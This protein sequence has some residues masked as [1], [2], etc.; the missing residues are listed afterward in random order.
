MGWIIFFAVIITFVLMLIATSRKRNSYNE[1]A[2][3]DPNYVKTNPDNLIE[4]GVYAGGHPDLDSDFSQAF[5]IKKDDTLLILEANDI[6]M[7]MLKRTSINISEIKDVV[8]ED[9]STFEKRVSLGRVML[10]GVFALAW[11]KQKQNENYFVSIIFNDGKF[12]HTVVFSYSK[13][14][15]SNPGAKAKLARNEIIRL[16]K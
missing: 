16:C 13:P 14:M 3:R 9:A 6:D 2:A 8:F 5:V 10:V 4:L 1:K 12:D 11:K 7:A 15:F